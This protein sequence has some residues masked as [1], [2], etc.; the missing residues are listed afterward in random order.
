MS[1]MTSTLYAYHEYMPYGL[2]AKAEFPAGIEKDIVVS[3][4]LLSCGEMEP[5]YKN[6]DYMVDMIGMWSRKWFR[7]FERW[8]KA[9]SIDYEPLYNYDRYEDISEE[10]AGESKHDGSNTRSIKTNDSE[11]EVTDYGG[12]DSTATTTENSRSAF[13]SSNYSPHDKSTTE[14][15]GE[16]K[17]TTD[18]D[19]TRNSIV[20]D[21]DTSAD[22]STS[23]DQMKHTG[24]LYGNIGVTTSQQMLRDELDISEW[25]IYEH[26]KDIFAQEFL[27]LVY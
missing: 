25:N 16:S 4:I 6:P 12:T 5:L 21:D 7:T 10:R 3:T 14:S 27:L 15:D 19:L 9:L 2:F 18:R 13:D 8:Q 11:N 1:S 20:S 17:S 26:I 24:H 22:A 23:S